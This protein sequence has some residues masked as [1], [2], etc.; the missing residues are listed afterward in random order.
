MK[1][2]WTRGQTY[3]L[4]V[5]LLKKRFQLGF[6]SFSPKNKFFCWKKSFFL[7]RKGFFVSHMEKHTLSWFHS[8]KRK[9]SFLLKKSFYLVS[10][11]VK[12]YSF[13]WFHS[14]KNIIS[15]C[16]T[17]EKYIF[18]YSKLM[19]HQTKIL[20]NAFF[21]KRWMIKSSCLHQTF[22][23]AKTDFNLWLR[24][25]VILSDYSVRLSGVL[26]ASPLM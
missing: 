18:L 5:S 25:P 16:L 9:K 21:I 6:S 24:W 1:K 10:E 15:L 8:W 26:T 13:Y 23:T 20:L 19:R 4:F 11:K 17:V 14:C 2:H 12:K 3:F 22:L 7:L